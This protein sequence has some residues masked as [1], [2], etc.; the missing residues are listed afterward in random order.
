[1]QAKYSESHFVLVAASLRCVVCIVIRCC[2][3]QESA[4]ATLSL[5]TKITSLNVSILIYLCNHSPGSGKRQHNMTQRGC[6]AMCFIHCTGS[7]F[8]PNRF[9]PLILDVCRVQVYRGDGFDAHKCFG[10]VCASSP[11]VSRYLVLHVRKL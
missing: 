4:T 6:K 5:Q 8:N 10:S 3:Q 11:V 9:S 7:D 1:M 2:S